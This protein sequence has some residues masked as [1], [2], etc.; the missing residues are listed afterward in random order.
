MATSSARTSI[1]DGARRSAECRLVRRA[2]SWRVR[3][4][5]AVRR[6]GNQ[7]FIAGRAPVMAIYSP[8]L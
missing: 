1:R 6:P 8:L 7:G 5:G 3:R 2:G 4:R